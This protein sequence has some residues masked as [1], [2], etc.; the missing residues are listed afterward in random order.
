MGVSVVTEE[1]FSVYEGQVFDDFCRV[2][3]FFGHEGFCSLSYCHV[4]LPLFR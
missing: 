1:F 4:F 2:V 3:F